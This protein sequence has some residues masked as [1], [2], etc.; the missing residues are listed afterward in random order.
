M[1]LLVELLS[2]LRLEVLL[3]SLLMLLE[4]FGLLLHNLPNI[5]VP[6]FVICDLIYFPGR[7]FRVQIEKIGIVGSKG[8]NIGYLSYE[9]FCA[10]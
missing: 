6:F 2:L 1:V 7:I 4:N 8:V 5:R 3:E 10:N 9:P